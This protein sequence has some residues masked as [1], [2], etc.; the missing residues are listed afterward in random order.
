LLSL[1]GITIGVFCII[2]ILT[3]V[4]SIQFSIQNSV[5]KL[6][7]KVVFVQKW[8]WLFSNDYPWWKYIS[9]PEL[10]YREMEVL[11]RRFP[12][13]EAIAFSVWAPAKKLSNGNNSAESVTV[14]G[15]SAD[16][17][18]VME[19]TFEDGRYFNEAE[20]QSGEPAIILG[21]DLMH[22]LFPGSQSAIGKSIHAFGRKLRV[23]GVQAKEGQGLGM[24]GGADMQ[25]MVPVNFIRNLNN[26]ENSQFNPTIMVK[27]PAAANFDLFEQDLHGAMR[28]IRK[29]SPRQ[30]DD[31]ATNKITML[32]TFLTAFFGKVS[33]YGWI[34]AGFSILVGGFGI[35]NIMF[36]SVQERTHI[37][38]IQKAIGAQGYFIMIQFL[39]EAIMLC[40]LG[41]LIGLSLIFLLS[42]LM[43]LVFPF[44]LVLT[45]K[46]CMIGIGLSSFIGI[47]S[48]YIPSR[49]AAKLDPIQA[50]RSKI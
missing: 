43:N 12:Q 6:G 47:I 34:I 18:K 50:I 40:I 1:S 42:Q 37:I 14:R 22:N 28:S 13:A 33:L 7:D 45:L 2:S 4:D 20:S 25:A 38:G 10:K 16:Y 48:G 46:N 9:R 27:A 17:D 21:N 3:L 30:E 31:F 41:G 15:L 49:Q 35:A 32:T 5:A 19:M 26:V 23:I 11:Q 29:L 36:V 8:P 44:K 39:G 24:D